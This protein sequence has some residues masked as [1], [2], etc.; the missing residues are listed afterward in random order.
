MEMAAFELHPAQQLSSTAAAEADSLQ[1]KPRAANRL[2]LL[3]IL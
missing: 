1:V 3:S 2:P